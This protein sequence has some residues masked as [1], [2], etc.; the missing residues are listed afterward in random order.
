MHLKAKLVVGFLVGINAV[1]FGDDAIVN[2]HGAIAHFVRQTA[3]ELVKE[4]DSLVM[5]QFE[6]TT[7]KYKSDEFADYNVT[8]TLVKEDGHSISCE[9]SL[10]V[11]KMNMGDQIKAESSI[12]TVLSPRHVLSVRT[13]HFECKL[14]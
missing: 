7:G 9:G 8:A 11:K 13:G 14:N 12:L 3:Q 1:S 2:A 4:S 5:T 10:P 6:M